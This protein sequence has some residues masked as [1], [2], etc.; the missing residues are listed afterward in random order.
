M[1]VSLAQ[2]VPPTSLQIGPQRVYFLP[3]GVAFARIDRLT[4]SNPTASPITAIVYVGDS[5]SVYTG[6]SIGIS[7]PAGETYSDP[8]MTNHV[9]VAG[10]KLYINSSAANLV[11]YVSGIEQS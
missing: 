10:D 3:E 4:L 11:A 5:A 1:T 6:V 9:L 8:N 2:L 7:V